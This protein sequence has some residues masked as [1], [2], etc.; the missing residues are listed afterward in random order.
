MRFSHLYKGVCPSVRRSV[1]LVRPSVGRSDLVFRLESVGPSVRFF[2]RGLLLQ[3]GTDVRSKTTTTTTKEMTKTT[4]ATSNNAGWLDA[5]SFTA[6][7][8]R[9][10][11]VRIESVDGVEAV[12]DFVVISVTDGRHFASKKEE[13]CISSVNDQRPELRKKTLFVGDDQ[14]DD[15]DDEVKPAIIV[16][17]GIEN[18]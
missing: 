5:A 4:M 2:K 12:K 15:D 13:I 10:G 1:A 18:S 16:G 7:D 9:S 14:D 6:S 8:I 11:V 3:P 17:E